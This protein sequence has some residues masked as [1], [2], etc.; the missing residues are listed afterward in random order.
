MIKCK[1]VI[2]QSKGIFQF[3]QRKSRFCRFRHWA[4]TFHYLTKLKM[5][6]FLISWTKLVETTCV[7]LCICVPGIIFSYGHALLLMCLVVNNQ[8]CST[9]HARIQKKFRGLG[10]VLDVDAYMYVI[11]FVGGGVGVRGFFSVILQ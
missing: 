6:K 8:L 7:L 2:N 4:T 5:K 3:N 1:K 11:L 10:C 9:Y